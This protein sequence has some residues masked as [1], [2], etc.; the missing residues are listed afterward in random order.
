[1][2]IGEVKIG[3]LFPDFGSQFVGMAKELYDHSRVMQEYFEEASSCLNV[4][5]IKLCFAASDFELSRIE[6]AYTSI[7]LTSFSIAE[8]LKEQGII[9]SVVAGYGIGEFSAAAAAG[10]LSLPDGL[11]FLNKY[12]QFYQE[13]L[14]AWKVGMIRVDGIKSLKMRRLCELASSGLQ[15][16]YIAAYNSPREFLVAGSTHLLEMLTV[17]IKEAGGTI[18][19]D[20]LERGLHGPIMDGIVG[21]LKKYLTKIDFKDLKIPLV[22]SI[23]A[24]PV[25]K[26]D[27][28]R[29]R[30]MKQIQVPILWDKVMKEA[31][32]WDIIIEVGPGSSLTRLAHEAYPDKPA[33]SINKLSDI[34]ELHT[35][36]KNIQNTTTT[37]G[38]TNE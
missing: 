25:Q 3:M 1:M 30:I 7:F 37:A 17:G 22:P 33:L 26:G 31:V 12:A 29:R 16:V 13:A 38:I 8:F 5:F 34:E 10:G 19:K 18:S 20:K 4:N 28:V 24:I 14:P 21:E 6:H 9:A 15:Q 35:M 36:I 23:D 11:Y 2:E 32:D 27:L